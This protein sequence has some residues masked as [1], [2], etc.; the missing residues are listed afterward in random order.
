MDLGKYFIHQSSTCS[1][2]SCLDQQIMNQGIL[3]PAESQP[4]AHHNRQ[5]SPSNVSSGSVEQSLLEQLKNSMQCASLSGYIFWSFLTYPLQTDIL[6]KLSTMRQLEMLRLPLS[7]P[8]TMFKRSNR[9]QPH[10]YKPLSC[11]MK[12][13]DETLRQSPS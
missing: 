13:Q 12:M 11:W 9:L 4:R 6:R 5:G 2:L 3:N 1:K 7:A 10:V 8:S